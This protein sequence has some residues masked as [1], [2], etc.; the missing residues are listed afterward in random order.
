M[1]T[2]VFLRPGTVIEPLVNRWYAWHALVSP[3]SMALYTANLHV[4]TMQ[5]F[6][7]N[8]EVHVAAVRDPQLLGGPFIHHGPDRVPAIRAL[9]E[10]T[11][12]DG[13]ELLELAAAVKEL[14]ALL[15]SEANGGSLEYLY[16]CVPAPLKGYVELAYDVHHR[17]SAKLNEPLLYRS[18]HYRRDLQSVVLSHYDADDRAF[19][20]TSPRLVDDRSLELRL[21][22][23]HEGLD[24]LARARTSST[25]LD[26][27]RDALSVPESDE[28][29]LASFFTAEPPLA[30][31]PP[32]PDSVRIRCL[33]HASVLLETDA[34]AVLV[35]PLVGYKPDV[36]CAD[37]FGFD[38]LP[39]RIDYVL[40]T[41]SHQDHTLIE[42]LIQLRHRVGTVI[43]PRNNAGSIADPS[44]KCMLNAI[45]FPRVVQV[46][47][48]DEIP[49]P[50]GHVRG[51]P[52]LGEHGDLAV[53][54]KMAYE[55]R[56]N[57]VSTLLVAD[58][59][60]LA[61]ELYDHVHEQTGDVDVLFIGME[62]AGAPMSWLYG[63]VAGKPLTRKMDQARRL[64]GSNCARALRLARSMK[65]KE[66]YVYAMGAEPWV[67]FL[68]AV[69]YTE[70]STP[71]VEANRFVST[72][73]SEGVRA[74]ILIGK[75]ELHRAA[76]MRAA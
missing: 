11:R 67:T 66:A 21:P 76:R 46:E 2:D 16:A 1:S 41:H 7:T 39:P 60:N 64:N 52:F 56:L 71:I 65:P 53:H 75:H 55:V 50:G 36:G 26:A 28:A 57:G 4:A 9:L 23:A 44:L 73:R 34:V 59:N 42:Y 49:V 19:A 8:P 12:R 58:S 70:E 69:K 31:R 35:D 17:A 30:P 25:T 72:L 40:L 45:G 29:K 74:D 33:G 68:T 20:L 15:M 43:V 48:L 62:C 63:P 37:R 54:S 38:D 3:A 14:D 22:F 61:P 32:A 47:D 24:A 51:I 13:A 10:A 5:S 27:I 6:V 18:R